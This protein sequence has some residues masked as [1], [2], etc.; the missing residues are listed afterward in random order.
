MI[1][2][3]EDNS[4]QHPGGFGRNSKLT[5]ILLAI[6]I[7]LVLGAI[8]CRDFRNDSGKILQS[9]AL[10]LHTPIGIWIGLQI[11]GSYRKTVI[12][13][14]YW[15]S[16]VLPPASFLAPQALGPLRMAFPFGLLPSTILI[17]W[18]ITAAL[19]SRNFSRR[20]WPLWLSIIFVVC[21][22][23]LVVINSS[24]ETTEFGPL[25]MLFVNMLATPFFILLPA[26]VRITAH[27]DIRFYIVKLQQ[28]T[29]GLTVLAWII[30]GLRV[31]VPH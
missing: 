2:E 11:T 23:A 18:L 12:A 1:P 9:L 19:L 7:A 24:F 14:V 3:P 25:G 28:I 27:E 15:I 8:L 20:R 16:V 29:Y 26:L 17:Q 13:A 31:S 22:A 4:R 21:G 30:F 10:F 6:D 5:A